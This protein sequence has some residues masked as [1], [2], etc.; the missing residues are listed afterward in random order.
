MAQP[1]T[2]VRLPTSTSTRAIKLRIAAP[3]RQ[4]VARVI[5]TA[6]GCVKRDQQAPLRRAIG[7]P[8]PPAHIGADGLFLRKLR[9]AP[10]RVRAS[11]Y[12]RLASVPL[13]SRA[14]GWSG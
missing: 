10:K 9:W 5:W 2:A 13:Y 14:W 11:R 4:F 8:D 12:R 3:F 1:S 6:S 7:A